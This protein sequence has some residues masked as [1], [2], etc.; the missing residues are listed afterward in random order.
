[1]VLKIYGVLGSQPVRAVCWLCKMHGIDF[2]LV[3]M[4]PG[5]KKE[6]GTKHPNYRAKVPSGTVPAME[7]TENGL[8]LFESNAIL[9]YICEKY[10][11]DDMWPTNDIVK[12]AKIQQWL[13]WHHSNSRIFTIAYFAPAAR[14]DLNFPEAVQNANVA[15]TRAA[16]DVLENHFKMNPYL[17]GNSATIADICIYEDI[18]QLD[19]EQLGVKDFKKDFPAMHAWFKRIEQLPKFEESHTVIPMLRKF[20]EKAKQKA[21]L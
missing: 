4:N 16:A 17:V 2:E 1:M 5:S 15:R 9:Q 19:S 21:N 13:H 10:G 3:Q 8:I 11:L 20:L 7:D 6:N 12:R 14:P 18:G